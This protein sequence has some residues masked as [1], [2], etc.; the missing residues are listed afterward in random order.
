MSNPKCSSKQKA[1]E[2][3]SAYSKSKKLSSFR[4]YTVNEKKTNDDDELVG[5]VLENKT[6]LTA[7]NL[8]ETSRSSSNVETSEFDF[9]ERGEQDNNAWQTFPDDLSKSEQH[10]PTQ[11]KLSVY[12]WRFYG[13]DKTIKRRF[14]TSFYSEYRGLNIQLK[15]MRLFVS[16]VASG[17]KEGLHFVYCL[18]RIKK[19]ST[20]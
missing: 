6:K 16:A 2:L 19:L 13:G 11:P 5:L 15:R 8:N 18:K 9:L 10:D 14:Q 4:R 3:A 17:G 12:P 20:K 7:H 1:E